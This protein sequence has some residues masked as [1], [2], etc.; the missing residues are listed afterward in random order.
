MRGLLLA[1]LVAAL[2]VATFAVGSDDTS[3]PVN[4]DTTKTCTN[5]TVWNPD[6]KSCVA[7]TDSSL[8][9][10]NLFRAVRELAYFGRLK[11][12]ERVLDAMTE[13]D[14]DGVLTY[15]GFI[16]RKSGR[17]DEAYEWYV[18]ALEQ[19]PDNLLARSYLG[20]GYVEEGRFELARAELSEIRARGGRATWA[21]FSL[22]MAL[23]SGQ[24]V[25]Y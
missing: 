13:Q 21:E 11:D 9:D 12:A 10:A 15:R 17:T 14:A 25:S 7:P 4:T 8:N 23:R 22:R 18:R 2:P 19:N 5:G 6:T 1:A 24:G 16:A 3:P 20:Q